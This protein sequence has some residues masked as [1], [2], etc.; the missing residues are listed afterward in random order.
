VFHH[1]RLPSI[2]QDRLPTRHPSAREV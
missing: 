1:S 2:R